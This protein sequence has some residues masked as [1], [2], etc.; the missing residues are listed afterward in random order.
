MRNDAITGAKTARTSLWIAALIVGAVI[1]KAQTDNPVQR[2]K[3]DIQTIQNSLRNPDSFI[4]E[5]AYVLNHGAG[6][7]VCIKY[8]AQNGFG[9]T[10]RNWLRFEFR[11][12]KKSGEVRPDFFVPTEG[13]GKAYSE[14]CWALDNHPERGTDLT[15]QV[16]ETK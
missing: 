5:A 1:C 13:P 4:L 8:R 6:S 2:A 3:D 7:S 14:Q 12:A 15:A 10:N 11:N 9:G 16:K